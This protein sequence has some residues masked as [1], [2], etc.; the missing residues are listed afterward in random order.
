MAVLVGEAG[1]VMNALRLPYVRTEDRDNSFAPNGLTEC[2]AQEFSKIFGQ[3]VVLVDDVGFERFIARE[4][5]TW[6]RL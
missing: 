2:E 4:D 6:V 5:G 1:G 3:T